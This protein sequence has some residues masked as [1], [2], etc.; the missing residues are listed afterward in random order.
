MAGQAA[1]N[2]HAAPGI[3]P[4][5]PKFLPTT[6]LY[7]A[8]ARVSGDT[9]TFEGRTWKLT[10]GRLG[11]NQTWYCDAQNLT[12]KD[13]D[14]AMYCIVDLW[15]SDSERA[16][17]IIAAFARLGGWVSELPATKE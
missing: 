13:V 15:Q 16:Q 3:R 4:M 11:R 6:D 8:L 5:K 10:A 14:E 17:K 7:E 2:I 1:W 12:P 9:I